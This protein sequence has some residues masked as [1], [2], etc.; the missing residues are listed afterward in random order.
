MRI[1]AQVQ[2]LPPESRTRYALG[3]YQ[4][5][6]GPNSN[7]FLRELNVAIPDLAFVF[8]HNAV[9]KDYGWWNAGLTPSGT[10]LQ[11]D[12][13]PVGLA[14]GLEEG[15]ELHV[16]QLTFALRFW[17]PRLALPILPA[18]PWDKDPPIPVAVTSCPRDVDFDLGLL[19]ME[20]QDP[21]NNEGVQERTEGVHTIDVDRDERCLFRLHDR[22][23]WIL[24]SFQ[25]MSEQACDVVVLI[26]GDDRIE[27]RFQV[28][29]DDSGKAMVGEFMIEDLEVGLRLERDPQQAKIFM[30]YRTCIRSGVGEVPVGAGTTAPSAPDR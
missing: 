21:G 26:Q 18:I 2:V 13:M 20:E 4:A 10:G 5:W 11:L 9:G 28:R 14:L 25:N 22:S 30:H 7:T 1:A 19:G 15:L 12:T 29:F 16:L 8:D 27:Q 6:P 3:G 24:V 23:G 17:P